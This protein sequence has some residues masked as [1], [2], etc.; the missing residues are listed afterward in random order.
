VTQVGE[1]A[2]RF[3]LSRSTLLYYD[4]KGVLSPSIRSVKG[5]RVYSEADAERLRLVCLYRK[6]GLSLDV[7]KVILESPFGGL[8]QALNERLGELEREV[9]SLRR[10]ERLILALL[11]REPPAGIRVLDKEQWVTLLKASGFSEKDMWAWHQA[12]ERTAPDRHQVFLEALGISADE[13]VAIRRRSK[14]RAHPR[15]R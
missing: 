3:G 8:E 13:I 5:Y 7:I 1:L 15:K 11:K 6:A 14:G 4:R 9:E 12:F 10:Q 2:R